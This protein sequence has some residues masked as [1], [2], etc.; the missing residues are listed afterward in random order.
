MVRTT[1]ILIA[2]LILEASIYGRN[3]RIPAL[4]FVGVGLGFTLLKA[5]FGFAGSF[6]AAL[7]RADFRGFRAQALSLIASTAV[8]FPLLGLSDRYGWGLDGFVAPVGVTFA[9][10]AVLFGIGMQIGGGCASGTL[11]SLGGGDGRLLATLAFFLIGSIF[12]AAQLDLWANLPRLP[13]A[14]AQDLFGW[15]LALALQICVLVLCLRNLPVSRHGTPD[16]PWP[17]VAELPFRPWP[18]ALGALALAA[19]NGLTLVLS[20]HPWGETSGF[21]LW[22][23]KI[24]GSLGWHPAEWPYW[25]GSEDA[26]NRSIFSDVTSVMDMGI[27]LGS[28]LAASLGRSFDL[29]FPSNAHALIGPIL[30]GLLMGYGAR[31][32]G[33]CNI[34]AYFSAIASGAL[35]GWAWVAF[36]FAGSALGIR[37]RRVIV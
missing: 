17:P 32:S 23:S 24:A 1:L 11:F 4:A 9:I 20:G 7:E 10:G 6:R 35:S 14:T 36:A 15:P 5:Q 27:V 3:W 31:L 21:T 2:C 12:G 30:G 13:A 29:R 22:G 33:G 26:L 18:L 37:L 34:G 19:L 16:H 8:F 28:A 25:Q